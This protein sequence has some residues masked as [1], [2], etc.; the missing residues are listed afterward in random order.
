VLTTETTE[1][2]GSVVDAEQ[3]V[4]PDAS[5]IVFAE[6]ARRIWRRARWVRPDLT[7]A[8]A[9]TGLPPGDYLAV[10]LADVDETRWYAPDYLDALRRQATRVTLAGGVKTTIVLPWS[11]VR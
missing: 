5:I 1:L 9:I 4:V 8:F 3:R 11:A 2:S 10:A 6:D 7:G